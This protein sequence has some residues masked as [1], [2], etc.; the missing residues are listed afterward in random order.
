MALNNAVSLQSKLD[1]RRFHARLFSRIVQK[2][3]LTNSSD[4]FHFF[5][6]FLQPEAHYLSQYFRVNRRY[7]Q[8][9]AVRKSDVKSKQE[10]ILFFKF[11]SI[12]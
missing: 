11:K 1:A 7:I 2:S 4:Y 9:Y 10:Y 12:L 6:L 5:S 8:R 3:Q